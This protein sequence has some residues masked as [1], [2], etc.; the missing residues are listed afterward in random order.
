MLVLVL[1]LVLVLIVGVDV[2]VGMVWWIKSVV[3]RVLLSTY[4]LC[5]C[6]SCAGE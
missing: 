1:V 4:L 5:V 3:S 6:V 2:D